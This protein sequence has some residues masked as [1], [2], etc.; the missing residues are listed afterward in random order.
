MTPATLRK[1][2]QLAAFVERVLAPEPAVQAVIAI[3]SVA[4]GRARPDSDIDAVVFLDPYNEYIVPAEFKWRPSDGSFHSIFEHL[5]AADAI[6]LDF[7]RLAL[8]QWADP[9]YEWPEGR[10]AELAAGWLAFDRSGRVSKLIVERTAYTDEVR[11]ARLDEAILWLDQHLADARPQ[12]SWRSLG[13]AIAHDRL[14]A[15]YEYLVQG[16]FAYNRRWRPWRNRQASALLSLSWLPERF[17]ERVLP[18][19]NAPALDETGYRAR[20]DALRGLVEDLT[21]RLVTDGVYGSEPTTEAF[22][23]SHQEPGLAWNMDEWN[24]RHQDRLAPSG[25]CDQMPGDV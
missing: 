13:P 21:I 23:R 8:A 6:Q 18:A 12:R 5:E 7:Y 9:G 22:V 4:S 10:R 16:L 1:R 19:L 3:G 20:V 2:H 24:K 11:E 14:Q 25:S 15:A 17:A